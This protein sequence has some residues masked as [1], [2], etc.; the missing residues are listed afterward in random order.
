[1]VSINLRLWHAMSKRI[2]VN[3]TAILQAC[4][5]V[6]V[7]KYADNFPRNRAFCENAGAKFVTS[8]RKRRCR[9]HTQAM[10]RT[11]V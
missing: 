3:G 11:P 7:K 5:S 2:I 9:I 8:Q 4:W 1:M 10:N 6:F